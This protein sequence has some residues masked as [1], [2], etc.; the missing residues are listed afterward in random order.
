VKREEVAA[1]PTPFD[2]DPRRDEDRI[3]AYRYYGGN[4]AMASAYRKGALA[5][6]E[7]KKLTDCPYLDHR[8]NRGSV[9]FS[10]AFE[11][12]WCEGWHVGKHGSADAC[13]K[14]PNHS[15]ECELRP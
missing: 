3:D 12:A 5:A 15:G 1:L 11:R 8:T 2:R 6:I 10:R 9:T 7:G 14:I 13:R 4:R